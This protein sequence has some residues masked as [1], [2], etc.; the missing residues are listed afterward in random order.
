MFFVE[1]E[2]E[3][4]V[5]SFPPVVFS[6]PISPPEEWRRSDERRRKENRLRKVPWF[7]RWD[8]P[9]LKGNKKRAAGPRTRKRVQLLLQLQPRSMTS[10]RSETLSTIVG[11]KKRVSQTKIQKNSTPFKKRSQKRLFLTKKMIQ[12][13]VRSENSLP[14]KPL[15]R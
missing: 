14:H 2:K 1:E 11:R 10:T 5:L 6:T 3:T 8:A 13:G 15:L 9:Y 4:I 7:P 12:K